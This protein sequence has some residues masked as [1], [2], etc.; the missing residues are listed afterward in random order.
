MLRHVPPAADGS[1]IAASRV[2]LA[3]GHS[4]RDLYR[5]L[6]RCDVHIAPKPFAV[7]FRRGLLLLLLLPQVLA[8]RGMAC[9]ADVW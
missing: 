1:T 3:P 4:A 5:T 7:G 6:L 9:D 2:V 8:W